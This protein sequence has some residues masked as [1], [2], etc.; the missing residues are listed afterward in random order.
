MKPYAL[1]HIAWRSTPPPLTRDI[2]GIADDRILAILSASTL[3][4]IEQCRATTLASYEGAL[5]ESHQPLGRTAWIMPLGVRA[6]ARLRPGLQY[7]PAC[8][9]QTPYY[10]R[11]WRVS[12][13]TVCVKHE[14]RLLDRCSHCASIL[15]PFRARGFACFNCGAELA[16]GQRLPA[17]ELVL[18]FQ[19]RQ[20]GILA[21]GWGELGTSHFPYS[22]QYFQTIR[23]VARSLSLGARAERF[24]TLAAYSWGGDPSP[25]DGEKRDI[26]VLTTVDRY[27]LFD[28]VSR[29]L[30]DWPERFVSTAQASGLWQSWALRDD[31]RPP[32]AYASMIASRLAQPSY[33]PSRAEVQSAADYLRRRTPSF[34]KRAL[35]NLVGES[36]HIR[37]VFDAERE[38]VLLPSFRDVDI[39]A[40]T[41]RHRRRSG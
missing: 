40:I 13:A 3:T 7:C 32:F 16:G 18:R 38:A 29:L 11:L 34:T 24:R 9:E 17:S 2:D 41:N 39:S 6:R 10:R 31:D 22:V 26:D 25:Y 4:P 5:F 8:M 19:L 30:E 23:H 33:S 14:L 28:L 27:R 20:E 21:Q 12:W 36:I 35:I 37:P 1:G 15:A